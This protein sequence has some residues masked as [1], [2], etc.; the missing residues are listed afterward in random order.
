MRLHKNQRNPKEKTGRLPTKCPDIIR[1]LTSAIENNASIT[2]SELKMQIVAQ[3]HITV[4]TNTIK[5]WIDGELFIVKNVTTSTNNMNNEQNKIKPVTY[6]TQFFRARSEGR[7]LIWVDETNF[8][9]YCKRREGRSRIGTR[10]S[11][12]LPASKGANLHCIGAMTASSMVNFTTRRGAFKSGDC[13]QWF[14]EL[15]EAC[16]RQGINEP[17]FI[18]DNA[19]AHCRLE[20]IIED[21]PHVQIIRLAPCSYLLNPIELVWSSFKSHI[22]RN[23]RD[24]IMNIVNIIPNGE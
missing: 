18:I 9:L 3:F 10:A 7:S 1:T 11:I 4:C 12:I 14:Q 2:L 6:M 23:F 20:E 8:N 13:V 16:N 5:N 15:I 22:K 24:E 21:N 19:P 17:T